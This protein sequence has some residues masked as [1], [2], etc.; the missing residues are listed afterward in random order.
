MIQRSKRT[1]K[2]EQKLLGQ[3]GTSASGQDQPGGQR[4]PGRDGRWEHGASEEA[5]PLPIP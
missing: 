1:A 2:K 3:E 4:D 5:A